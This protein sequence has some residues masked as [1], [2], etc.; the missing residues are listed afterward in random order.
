MK[1]SARTYRRLLLGIAL[2]LAAAAIAAPAAQ[3]H[4]PAAQAHAMHGS[5]GC[6]QPPGCLAFGG[7]LGNVGRTESAGSP[8]PDW[9]LR[10]G[11]GGGHSSG[12]PAYGVPAAQGAEDT[13]HPNPVRGTLPQAEV[14]NLA[15][16]P[17]TA[18]VP[19]TSPQ[20]EIAQLARGGRTP[21]NTFGPRGF[22]WVDAGIGASFGLSLA[23]FL[24]GALLAARR[25]GRLASA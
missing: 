19:G 8:L 1:N 18:P 24:I 7:P 13:I 5:S 15:R 2:S 16:S 14:G 17:S 21:V 4:D 10:Y 9:Q 23:L 11:L 6:G 20:A 3:A 22:D 12:G 25:R